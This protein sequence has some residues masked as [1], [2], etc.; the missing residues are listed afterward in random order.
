[1]TDLTA[2]A[3]TLNAV[4]AKA[5]PGDVLK[6]SGMFA[7]AVFQGRAFDPP[8]TVDASGATLQAVVIKGV[9]GL[10]WTGGTFATLT[11]SRDA[12]N[13]SAS[14]GVI[15]ERLSVT[16]DGT[17]G[18]VSFRD[19]Q[20]VVLTDSRIDGPRV[21]AS[22]YNVARARVVGN[23]ITGWSADAIGLSAVSDSL[24][25]QNSLTNPKRIDPDIH[26]DGIQGYFTGPAVNRDVTV[27]FNFI[28]GRGTQGIF[29]N[30]TAG[31]PPPE[32]IHI[33]GNIVAIDA[34]HG[35]TL[36]GDPTGIVKNNRIFTLPGAQWQA[37]LYTSDPATVRIGNFIEAY[38]LWK[39]E[40]DEPV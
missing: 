17:A 25:S 31:Y 18:A 1:M 33:E 13:V 35:V 8:L 20:D 32:R 4:F 10:R 38:G 19:C 16:G 21:G 24:I 34:V 3:A 7:L 15:L 27:S 22:L 39:A 12:V 5:A 28:R 30:T 6:L 9:T 26:I 23:V 29:F 36:M 40:V 37:R 11:K 14:Q 2:T